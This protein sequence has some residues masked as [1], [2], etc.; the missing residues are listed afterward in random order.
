LVAFTG[1]L[2]GSENEP[3]PGLAEAFEERPVLLTGS[4]VDEW[5][6][7]SHVQAA[8]ALLAQSGARVVLRS[9]LGRPHSIAKAEIADAREFLSSIIK[10]EQAWFLKKR[11]R[12]LIA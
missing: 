5:V 10:A 4:D 7:E 1:A 3:R 2:M 11:L 12:S 6:E 9:Y 8:A